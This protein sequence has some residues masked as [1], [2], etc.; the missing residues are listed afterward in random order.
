MK[1]KLSKKILSAFLAM[2]M[3]V[4]SVPLAS[5]TAFAAD[6]AAV[7]EVKNAMAAFERQLQ[8][9]GAFTNVT[10]AY[11]AYVDCQKAL[12]A[13]IYGGE[14]NALT[15]KAS[16]LNTAISQI[17]TFTGY[18]GTAVPSFSGDT[19]FAM[20]DYAEGNS[21]ANTHGAAYNNIL[22]TTQ[23]TSSN[24][25]QSSETGKVV[26]RIFYPETTLLYDGTNDTLMPVMGMASVTG[27]KTRYIYASYPCV[28]ASDNNDNAS[29]N[30]R[31]YW[32]SSNGGTLDFTWCYDQTTQTPGYNY[33]TGYK[34]NQSTDHRSTQLTYTT[35]WGAF[36]SG[37]TKYIANVM[38]FVG[39]P[40][41]TYSDYSLV[42]YVSSGDTANSDVA[43]IN[44]SASVIHVVNYK[45]L[46]D[47][48]K[49][50]GNKMKLISPSDFSEG[51][52]STYI[53][54]M[55]AA[56]SFDP[57]TYFTS[58]NNY[59]GCATKI[60]QLVD[61]MNNAPVNV[62][63]SNDYEALRT[64]MNESVRTQYSDGNTGYTTD[65]WDEFV[66]KY[67]AA[68]AIMAACNDTGYTST[69]A[70]TAAAELTTAFGN[71]QTLA[72]KVNTTSLVSAIDAFQALDSTYFT[73]E[74][75]AAVKQVVDA[76]KV[77]VWGAVDEYN[78]PTSAL[79]DSTEAQETVANQ[80]TNVNEAVKLLR[81]TP[82]KIV[83]LSNGDKYSLNS[84]I[85]LKDTI[86][87][88][89]DYGN[90]T[91]YSD[92]IDAA[93]AY[94]TTMASTEFTDFNTQ[95]ANYLAM[96]QATVDSYNSLTYAFT[97]IPDGTVANTGSLNAIT[98]LEDH[99][100]DN[101]YNWW[102]DFSYPSSGVILKTNHDAKT[103]TY[104][105][106]KVGFKINIDNNISKEN[107]SL[108][109]ITINGTADANTQINSKNLTSTPPAL[110]DTEKQTYS[111]C[112][113]VDGFSL[114]NF[115]VDSSLNNAKSYFGVLA[116]GSTISTK[117]A[118]NDEYTTILSTTE[119]SSANPATGCIGLQPGAKGDSSITLAADM[120]IDIP[121]TTAATLSATTKP[122]KTIYNLTGHY[123]GATYVWNTQPTAAYA[124]YA[125]LTSK[126]NNQM[127]TSSVTVIDISNLVDLVSICDRMVEANEKVMYTEDSWA[128]FTK[129]LKEAKADIDYISLASSSTGV[130]NLY[131]RCTA[132]YTTLWNAKEGLVKKTFN[133]AFNY[134][135][136]NGADATTSF[137]AT[138]GETLN[139]YASTINKINTP[140]YVADNRTYTFKEWTPSVNLDTPITADATYTATYDSVL[141]QAVF[142]AYNTAKAQ[143]LGLL[144]DDVYTTAALNSLKTEV[145][146]MTYFLYDDA[147]K[148]ATMAD[149]QAAIDA[150]TEKIN[151]L[152]SS[153]TPAGLDLSTAKAT[154]AEAKMAGG[155]VDRYDLSGFDF[156]YESDVVIAGVTVKGLTFGDKDELDL[157]IQAA[158]ESIQTKTYK[159]YLNGNGASN[160]V[161]AD[162]PYGTPVIVNS[163]GTYVL[164]A[165]DT[166][167]NYDGASAGW[168]YSYNAPSRGT[169]GATI[170][171]YMLSAP[172]LGF[173]VKGDTYLTAAVADESGSTYVVTVKSSTGKVI[174]MASTSGSYTMPTAPSYFGY[175][176]DSYDNGASAGDVINVPADTTIIANYTAN[177]A[178]NFTITTAACLDDLLT[179]V[180]TVESYAYN[181]KVN[182]SNPDAYCWVVAD[183]YYDDDNGVYNDKYTLVSFNAGAYSFYACESF[184]LTSCT[185]TCIIGKCVVP[186]TYGEYETL[187]QDSTT[188][189]TVVGG[190][191]STSFNEE[192]TDV[193]YDG[194][195]NP[196][197]CSTAKKVGARP[198]GV[199]D[200]PKATVSSLSTVLNKETKFAMIGTFTLPEGYEIVECGFLFT[201]DTT[202]TDMTV[203]KVG[204]N[205]ISRMKSSIYTVGNQFVIN[206]TNPSTT[207]TFKY[208][209]YAIVK[210]ADGNVDTV[211]GTAFTGSNNF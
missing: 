184:E 167:V 8:T 31:G 112:L 1:T 3:V 52:L 39:T 195:G 4:T 154:V 27:K 33:A 64:A 110:S 57:N 5:V 151:T 148:E 136:A 66:K 15:G 71:L 168:T 69:S 41:S 78:I 179:G 56:T 89:T 147:Q 58:S 45:T 103:V 38:K 125:Y 96:V 30:L 157:A 182:L 26:H 47:A 82:D 14:A 67:D 107:N 75:Y 9:E 24:E 19:T 109:S 88:P 51:G 50:N 127:I 104:G 68:K 60:S 201:S 126:S 161:V 163:D 198:Q 155:D 138:Y 48:L 177:S 119:G 70:A 29:F 190:G 13:Y 120:N 121:A 63:D 178:S 135:D 200:A 91:D 10:N 46:T 102:I 23:T 73:A 202:V 42:W 53:A 6:D 100:N 36:K 130:T 134:K 76:A 150:E 128:S 142:T 7:T 140:Q 153:L 185:E 18:K 12:D 145:D 55:D 210:D 129:A 85:A 197:Y 131:N 159:I 206:I 81:I 139:D 54:A 160:V 49:T 208:A 114:T 117:T 183:M 90:Y 122:T 116:D 86:A 87:D 25:M 209:P 207:V 95:T 72:V 149:H 173:I 164:D 192:A 43:T 59:T 191:Y 187:V 194:A 93:N 118:P 199:V 2:L 40:A 166:N 169:A 193:I 172:S 133:I 65:S 176:F 84:A 20:T 205:G 171:K 196:V 105:Q 180:V 34:G 123:F 94:V 204:T 141:N 106:A 22:Y 101:G 174:D 158:L 62:K 203:E 165:A 79:D 175:T 99:K 21:Q 77:A 189:E 74:S 28:S 35:S 143:L 83:T 11:N 144:V 181:T 186:L 16:D 170:P 98:T 156:D 80:T 37:D 44:A 115:R 162:V 32:H 97:K 108:D 92:Q 61:S 124:G 188:I 152:I 137:V 111:G 211:Y 146:G 17:G 113:A 132:R